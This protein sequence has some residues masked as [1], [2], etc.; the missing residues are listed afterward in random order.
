MSD[1]KQILGG[2]IRFFERSR[3]VGHTTAM[4]KGAEN[5]E[6]VIIVCPYHLSTENMR[7]LAP[8]AGTRVL[9]EFARPVTDSK[10]TVFDN[11][12]ILELCKAALKEILELGARVIVL[13]RDVNK[14]KADADFYRSDL[15][16]HMVDLEAV[17][18]RL[19]AMPKDSTSLAEMLARHGVIE[20]DAIDDPE[21]YDGYDTLNRVDTAWL[22]MANGM[23]EEGERKG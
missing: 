17:E 15:K 23:E 22:E 10:P 2:I 5:T 19:K 20:R 8:R 13:T 16:Q 11:F 9:R 6:D 14:A 12:A 4:I 1:V 3:Q 21:G 7:R 18:N